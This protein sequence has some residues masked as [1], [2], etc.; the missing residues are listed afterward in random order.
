MPIFFF[1]EVHDIWRYYDV[2]HVTLRVLTYI[3]VLTGVWLSH[4]KPIRAEP[5]K[6]DVN[7]GR[8][9]GCLAPVSRTFPLP[10]NAN[11]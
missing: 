3:S 2:L 10:P 4:C 7:P 1:N 6:A 9:L 8:L 11:C 5:I